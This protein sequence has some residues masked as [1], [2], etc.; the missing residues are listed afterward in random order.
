M[1]VPIFYHFIFASHHQ[2]REV[3][4]G[5]HSALVNGLQC[6]NIMTSGKELHERI[7]VATW[8]VLEVW[9][10]DTG[11]CITIVDLAEQSLIHSI[12]RNFTFVGKY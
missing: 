12:L 11:E 6:T 4:R 7:A 2:S 1:G 9:D 5:S 10:V 8:G 3:V